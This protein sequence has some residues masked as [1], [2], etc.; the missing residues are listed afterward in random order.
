MIQSIFIQN[1][2]L[3]NSLNLDLSKGL[4]ILSGETGSGKSIIL[5]AISLLCGK[6]SDRGSLLD[7]DKLCVLEATLIINNK[8]KNIFTDHNLHY[9]E[10]SIIRREISHSGKNR[11]FIND[12]LVTLS[13]LNQVMSNLIDI[14]SQNYSISL[15]S[16]DKQLELID[17]LSGSFNLLSK[18]QK[19]F[20]RYRQLSDEILI[21]KEGSQLS[22]MEIDFLNHQIQEIESLNLQLDEKDKLES[23]VKILENSKDIIESLSNAYQYL[24]NENGILSNLSKI[25]SEINSLSVSSPKIKEIKDRISVSMI[26]LDDLSDS[27]NSFN[28]TIEINP[29]SLMEKSTRLDNI[30]SLLVKHRKSTI[31]EILE[32]LKE[33]KI[34]IQSSLDFEEIILDKKNQ[35]NKI[36][37]DLNKASDLLT[38]SRKSIFHNFKKDI[39]SYLKKL[40]IKDPVFNISLSEKDHYSN[41]GKDSVSFMFS[42]NK[43][44]D[45]AEIHKV[46][47][48]GELSRLMLCISYLLSEVDDVSSI[49]FDEIDAGVSGE[50]ASLMSDMMK[51]MS[52]EKQIISVTHL[53]QIASNGDTHFKVYKKD[54]QNRTITQVKKLMY[55]DRVH[56]IA[57]M[58]SGKKVTDI[59]ISNAKELLTT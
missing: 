10:R 1:F 26:E 44:S 25:N 16:E 13:V 28:Q 34:K 57:K 40:G 29:E 22:D 59:S 33:M 42:A 51:R 17:K 49:I 39:E 21:I 19:I 38:K 50:I 46:A 36:E 58:L 45:P 3:I 48:G 2:A 47:S 24:S 43:G 8:G 41:T 56:E 12:H 54:S 31:V 9:I 55:D 11:C 27:I 53:P 6:R 18:Y 7:K 35:L 30:N 23:D 14:Y 4:T 15:K 20:T 37:I 5:D 32:L 52:L